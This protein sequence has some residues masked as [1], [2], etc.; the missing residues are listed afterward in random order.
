MQLA[1]Y[2]DLKTT[3][4]KWGKIFHRKKI[5]KRKIEYPYVKSLLGSLNP[6]ALPK[7]LNVN[8][9]DSSSDSKYSGVKTLDET[10]DFFHEHFGSHSSMQA[11]YCDGEH[12]YSSD[13]IEE[14]HKLIMHYGLLKKT[15]GEIKKD[16]P[17]RT[18]T[19]DFMLRRK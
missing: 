1:L 15:N 10:I 19:L 3:I 14:E 8:Y 13:D 18:I 12:L 6:S 11:G 2:D 7:G 9:H 17:F 16:K 5:T 4:D